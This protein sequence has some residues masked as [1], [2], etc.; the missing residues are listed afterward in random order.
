MDKNIFIDKM[1]EKYD[2]IHHKNINSYILNLDDKEYNTL[3]IAY[4]H[5]ESSF[6]LLKS[7]GYVSFINS[8]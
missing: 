5:L 1:Y 8:V 2:E 4:E 3:I 7:I 6:H